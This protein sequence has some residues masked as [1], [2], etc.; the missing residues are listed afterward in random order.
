VYKIDGAR[1]AKPKNPGN[2]HGIDTVRRGQTVWLMLYYT[3]SSVPST[4]SRTTSYQIA[5]NGRT[6]FAASYPTQ[7][8]PQDVGKFTRY[9]P[10]TV[11]RDLATGIYTLRTQ[12]K[13]GK[14]P[15]LSASWSFAVVS[16]AH[17]AR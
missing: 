14:G 15:M 8:R 5:G 16:G 3:V 17:L 9:I 11:P 7:Q 2:R 10:Y 13:I 6:V 1:V 12:L 4:L